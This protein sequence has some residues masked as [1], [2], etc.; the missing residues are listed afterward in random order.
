MAVEAIGNALCTLFRIALPIALFRIAFPIASLYG[1]PI[2]RLDRDPFLIRIL[3]AI[4]DDVLQ[5]RV[6]LHVLYDTTGHV[7]LHHF[8]ERGLFFLIKFTCVLIHSK[9]QPMEMEDAEGSRRVVSGLMIHG[10]QI[11]RTAP[12]FLFFVLRVTP[13]VV[14][15][16]PSCEIFAAHVAPF[17]TALA[18]YVRAREVFDPPTHAFGAFLRYGAVE[19]FHS[20]LVHIQKLHRPSAIMVGHFALGDHF[21]A[22]KAQGSSTRSSL[23]LEEQSGQLVLIQVAF[24]I[25]F[26]TRA[27]SFITAI[28][29]VII[30]IIII[31]AIIIVL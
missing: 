19:N 10:L 17:A 15:T 30:S 1:N 5:H 7:P 29:A 3:D 22:A 14:A 31:A 16:E 4:F 2:P 27:I 13:V 25:F 6:G 18:R 11:L 24:G 28:A 21:V 23:A 20:F 9:H 26:I 12:F 8:L